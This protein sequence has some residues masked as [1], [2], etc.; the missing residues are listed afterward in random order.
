MG[1]LNVN[2]YVKHNFEDIKG[3]LELFKD[4]KNVSRT[5]M[6]KMFSN[7]SVRNDD[8]GKV[9]I[10]PPKYRVTDYFDLPKGFLINQPNSQ[11]NTTIGSYIFNAFIL[12]N[13]FENGKIAYYDKPLDKDNYESFC[14]SLANN[15]LRGTISVTEYGK[16]ASMVTWLSYFTELF[17][18]GVSLNFIVPNKELMAYKQQLL[19][20]NKELLSK[21]IYDSDDVAE[22]EDKI[23]GPLKKKARELLKDDYTM[24]VYNL[25]KPSFG[26]NFKNS[27]IIN[28]PLFDPVSGK[29]KINTK[30]YVQGIDKD[31]FDM[32]AN[33]AMTSSFSRAVAT[34]DGGTMTKYLSVAMQNIKLGP[35]GSD[36]GTKGFMYYKISDSGHWNSILYDYMINPDNTLTLLTPELK[37]KLMGKTIKIR[38][39]LYCKAKDY[40]CNHCA[41]DRYYKLGIQDIGMTATTSTGTITNKNMKAMHDVSIKTTPMH[42]EDLI[43]FEK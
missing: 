24:R 17:M 39:P 9:E 6:N 32:L 35:K 27:N 12:C 5:L 3:D 23:E 33:K 21:K 40:Y 11:P 15:I 41:G 2:Q 42:I 37:S 30:S 20:E 25:S 18:P 7:Q 13:A 10:K 34:Q 38:T 36:C 8:T 19:D 28:G 29:Y 14:N 16:F 4:E 26:N 1:T 22:F 31:S 43:T